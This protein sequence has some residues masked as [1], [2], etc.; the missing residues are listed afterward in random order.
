MQRDS[1]D[2]IDQEKTLRAA[3]AEYASRGGRVSEAE[4]FPHS[5]RHK[6]AV[7]PKAVPPADIDP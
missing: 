1:F 2:D 4:A 6:K 7:L 5:Q 3:F